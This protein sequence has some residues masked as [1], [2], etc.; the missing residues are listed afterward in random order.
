MAR[1]LGA[2]AREGCDSE[3][4]EIL[5]DCVGVVSG[6]SSKEWEFL[7]GDDWSIGCRAVPG[8]AT[9]TLQGRSVV[10]L[11]GRPR[12]RSAPGEL[13]DGQWL[14]GRLSKGLASMALDLGGG[15]AVAV[16]DGSGKVE[17]A[18]D[19][20]A[21]HPIC[22][23][24][25]AGGFIFGS[26]ARL[27]A[28]HPRVS[29]ELDPQGL[30]HYLYFHV[31]PSPDSVFREVRYLEPGSVLEW[32]KG[33]VRT[34][35]YWT[36]EFD[37]ERGR[38]RPDESDQFLSGLESAV[39]RACEGSDSVG[40]FLSGGT[41][42]SSIA[43]MLGR[44]TGTPARTYSIGFD[45][46]GFD[47]RH[48]ARLASAHFNTRHREYVVTP[49]DVV[50]SAPQIAM[51]YE[52]PFGNSSVVPTY[53][54]ARLAREDGVDRMLGGDGG[55]ELFGGNERY[56]KQKIFGLYEHL[57]K[58][59]RRTVLEK[60]LLGS[61]VGGLPL[62]RKAR[63]YVAQARLPM[64]DRMESYN[65]LERSGIEQ[66]C[67]PELL[68]SIDR[69]RPR[70]LLRAWYEDARA[71]TMLNRMLALDFKVTLADSD[72]PKVTAMCW[73]AG[74]E[75]AYPMLDAE[76]VDLA[77]TLPV[78]EKVRG[79]RLRHFFKE[80]LRG[81]LPDEVL[82][83]EK[84]GFGLPFGPWAMRDRRLGELAFDSVSSLKERGIVN[85]TF[86]DDLITRRMREHATYY[87]TMLWVLMVLELWLAR[88][89]RT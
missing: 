13:V 4:V 38:I 47:E 60:A 7:G 27:V 21:S 41:D 85:A 46:R 71:A 82:S 56:V 78:V 59:F 65:H 55:D 75:V 68:A 50:D 40:C 62:L 18:T 30:F 32:S 70:A 74:V 51:S 86:I 69:S 58:F 54:C 20:F 83:K 64:P 10:A 81:F 17:L 9:A 48:Y 23:A 15:F 31:I 80:S 25:P 33:S 66:V 67:A 53:Y 36:P 57:P 24:A 26:G 52:Q 12:S 87:G 34:R 3:R 84:H 43:G 88:S 49:D 39:K 79:M 28:S 14:A 2:V 35:R 73:L 8:P 61:P 37:N 11:L 6:D 89:A 44:V 19:R 1:F 72:L 42:S 16:I 76:V 22:Y 5:R 29:S 45:E 63:S 77:A